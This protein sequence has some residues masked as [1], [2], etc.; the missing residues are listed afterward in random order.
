ME[1]TD[2]I[3]IKSRYYFSLQHIQSAALF[4]RQCYQIEKNYDGI[5][6]IDLITEHR[7]YVI[8]SLFAAFSFLEATINEFF[9]D[10]VD[11]PYGDVAKHLDADTK[12]LMTDLWVRGTFRTTNSLEKFQ[13]ALTL[14][15]KPLLDSH[16]SPWQDV[17]ILR[18]IRNDFV[19]YEP[20][21]TSIELE[22]K[23]KN[24]ILNLQQQKKFAFNPLITATLNPFY[25]DK[26]LSHGCAKWAINSSVQLA[27]D[28]FSKIGVPIPFEHIRPQLK[29]EIDEQQN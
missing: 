21:W 28:F 24:S 14:A 1:I 3:T 26:C 25:P 16:S 19:H 4:A 7:S 23:R 5:F 8:G 2:A 10:T 11:H 15:R 17:Q 20:E 12:Q 9:A 13:V 18:A 6:S 27:E 29:T 22:K